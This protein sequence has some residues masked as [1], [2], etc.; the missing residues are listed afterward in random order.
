MLSGLRSRSAIQEQNVTV[1]GQDATLGTVQNRHQSGALRAY[2]LMGLACH[3]DKVGQCE[4]KPEVEDG[5]QGTDIQCPE[6][7]S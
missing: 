7:A 1:R 4:N 3:G 6:S 5:A 2:G